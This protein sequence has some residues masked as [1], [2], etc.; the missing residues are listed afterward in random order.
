[1][2]RDRK[3]LKAGLVIL[4]GLW[5]LAGFSESQ[6]EP[7]KTLDLS[8][9]HVQSYVRSTG[10]IASQ[11]I[12]SLGS[13]V[14]SQDE[15]WNMT[16]GDLVYIKLAPGMRVKAGDQFYLASL[17]REVIH[18][19]TKKRLG[20]QLKIPGVIVVL[21][22]NGQTVPA[23]IEKSFF[24]VRYGD[25][26]ISPPSSLPAAMPIRLSESIQGTLVASPEGEENLTEGLAVYIDRGSQDG[27]IPGDFFTIYH[28]PYYTAE[29]KENGGKLPQLKVG[30]GV[31]VFVNAETSTLLITKS[32]QQLYIGDTI[33]SGRGK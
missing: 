23:R 11:P 25:T 19:I 5:I 4:F 7:S 27:V 33:V 17:G 1:M 9:S 24:Q 2:K 31:V 32:S 22:G 8:D 13:I 26:L 12:P 3:T 18:P 6:A 16:E 28:T 15:T 14:G 10:F 29:A 30:E 20:H 21:D